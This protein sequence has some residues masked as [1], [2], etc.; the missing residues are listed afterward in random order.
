[1]DAAVGAYLFV[2]GLV[3]GS[4]Y[5]VV[6]LRLPRGESVIYPPSSCGSCGMRL[7]ARHLVPVFS[8]IASRGR[9]GGCR[10]KISLLY[11]A[12]ELATGLLFVWVYS[13][14]GVSEGL[15]TG[16][17]LVS[18]SVMV[19]IADLK[20]MLIPNKLLLLFLV[21]L[22]AAVS[23]TSELPLWNH[24]LGALTGGAVLLLIVIVSKGGMGMGDVKLFALLGWVLGLPLVLLA[25]IMACLAGTV[26]GGTLLL[27]GH[28]QRKQPVPFG[29]FLAV[30]AL[31]AY[32]YGAAIVDWYITLFI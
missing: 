30:G 18:L 24:A 2:L 21:P 26:I 23:F 8:Y 6:G 5:N 1:M 9:C 13:L 22:V 4:F 20:Y 28:I 29:P 15:W 19:T 32:G 25:L 3:L 17:L 10:A 27:T 16:L 31:A 7:R 11:P 12:G 14:H